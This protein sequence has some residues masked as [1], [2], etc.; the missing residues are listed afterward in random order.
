MC[1]CKQGSYNKPKKKK[2]KKKKREIIC[3]SN[4]RSRFP[5]VILCWPYIFVLKSTECKDEQLL[6]TA[7]VFY[8]DTLVLPAQLSVECVTATPSFS[9]NCPKRETLETD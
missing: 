7:S 2:K 8:K 3:F 4:L 9:F 5:L 1:N 6:R